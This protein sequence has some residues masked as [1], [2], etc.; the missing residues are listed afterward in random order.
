[1]TDVDRC[2]VEP[3]R[4]FAVNAEGTKNVVA[5]AEAAGARVIYLSTDYVFDGTK[6]TPYVEEDLPHPLNRYGA[7]KL[8]GERHVLKH[9]DNVVVRTSW[10]MGRGRNFVRTILAAARTRSELSVVDDQCG[11]PTF[12]EDLAAALLALL[13]GR[14]AGIVHVSGDGPPCSWA[15]LAEQA[16]AHARSS[17][18]I[19]RIDS[20]AYRRSAGK[21]VA[22]R[23]RNSA[24]AL[25][26][27]RRLSLPLV[28]WRS[29]LRRYVEEIA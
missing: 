23:P 24:F 25:D 20:E 29:S 19:R 10:V 14:H 5:A 26:K 15:D 3:D 1:M 2:E 11:R 12:A 28:D 6:P 16:L 13:E 8:E 4:A 7:S 21:V 18:A 9:G 27:A 22:L 17:A